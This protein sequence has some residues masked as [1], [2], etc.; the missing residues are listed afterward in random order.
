[1]TIFQ[2]RSPAYYQLFVSWNGWSFVFT[3][4]PTC[5]SRCSFCLNRKFS[6]WK[7]KYRRQTC[8]PKWIPKNSTKQQSAKEANYENGVKGCSEQFMT[9]AAQI[10]HS[11]WERGFVCLKFAWFTLPQLTNF[12]CRMSDEP[13]NPLWRGK[14]KKRLFG[15]FSGVCFFY[16]PGN[17]VHERKSK[18]HR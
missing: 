10:P 1:M 3:R 15:D 8:L 5:Q 16:W 11:W 2:P 4:N 13:V 6:G 9:G 17:R 18:R 12:A 14:L 7:F